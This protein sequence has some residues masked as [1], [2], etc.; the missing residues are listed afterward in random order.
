MGVNQLQSR[1][2]HLSSAFVNINIPLAFNENISK[3]LRCLHADYRFRILVNAYR[4]K[5][6]FGEGLGVRRKN[7]DLLIIS[8]DRLGQVHLQ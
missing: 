6:P 7:S 2:D 1:R 3:F 5:M 8:D 4:G